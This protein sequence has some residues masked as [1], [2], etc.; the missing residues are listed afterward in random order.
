MARLLIF[1]MILA[2]VT[3]QGLSA[4][5][6]V[7]RHDTAREHVQA[8]QSK[9]ASIASL[10]LREDA[11]SSAASKATGS[12]DPSSVWPAKMLPADSPAPPLRRAERLPV[13]PTQQPA[14]SSRSVPPLL[15]PP[16]A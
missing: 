2:V 5:A 8:R 3:T 14:L 6:A 16:S 7:C 12:G 15:K 9:D 4:A 13:R 1:L 10:S 11:A